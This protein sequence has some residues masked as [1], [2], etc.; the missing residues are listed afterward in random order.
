[1]LQ[2][3]FQVPHAKNRECQNHESEK[4]LRRQAPPSRRTA[5]PMGLLVAIAFRFGIGEMTTCLPISRHAGCHR[6]RVVQAIKYS[7]RM[8]ARNVG[9]DNPWS[10]ARIWQ[11]W[12]Q[13]KSTLVRRSPV[14]GEC[15]K[16]VRKW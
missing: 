9:A 13:T 10:S 16:V 1:M 8:H 6:D 3:G 12:F 4:Y 5:F 14:R 7:A 11:S 2:I 15:G